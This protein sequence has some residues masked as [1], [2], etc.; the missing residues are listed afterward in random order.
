MYASFGLLGSRS[1][2]AHGIHNTETEYDRWAES[3][4]SVIHC[5]TSNTFLGSG[6]FDADGYVSRGI[7]VG[8]GSDVGGGSSLNLVTMVEAYKVAKPVA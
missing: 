7:N 2:F 6:L 3:G 8:L 1:L 5:P 4:A